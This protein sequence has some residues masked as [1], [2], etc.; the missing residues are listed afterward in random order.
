MQVGLAY[1]AYLLLLCG[2]GDGLV[3]EIIDHHLFF[4]ISLLIGLFF[5]F[6]RHHAKPLAVRMAPLAK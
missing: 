5:S 3:I 2:F 4:Y 1:L 6:E